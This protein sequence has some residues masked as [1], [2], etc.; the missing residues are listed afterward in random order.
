MIHKTSKPVSM[1]KHGLNYYLCTMG[2]YGPAVALGIIVTLSMGAVYIIYRIRRGQR[3]SNVP[4]VAQAEKAASEERCGDKSTEKP[5]ENREAQHSPESHIKEPRAALSVPGEDQCFDPY[6]ATADMLDQHVANECY[7]NP[8]SE[9]PV[10]QNKYLVSHEEDF[11]I[12]TEY[13]TGHL[14]DCHEQS[15][16]VSNNEQQV[17]NHENHVANHNKHP[18]QL[19]YEDEEDFSYHNQSPSDSQEY[20]SHHQEHVCNPSEVKDIDV[21]IEQRAENQCVNLKGQLQEKF[22]KADINIQQATVSNHQEHPILEMRNDD[23]ESR[24]VVQGLSSSMNHK[25]EEDGDDRNGTE[26]TM[27]NLQESSDHMYL[28]NNVDDLEGNLTGQLH[29]NCEKSEVNI[30]EATNDDEKSLNSS[31]TEIFEGLPEVSL[32]KSLWNTAE[33]EEQPKVPVDG[34]GHS[35]VDILKDTRATTVDGGTSSKKVAAVHPMPQ[36][37]M[38]CF[39]THFLT[40]S[41]SQLLAVTGNLQELGG[42]ENFF[43][44]SQANNGFWVGSVSLPVNSHV[45]WK[46]VLLEHGKIE[47]WEECNNHN[48]ETRCDGDIHLHKSWGYL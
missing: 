11:S 42:W 25:P 47:R 38:V 37:V 26:A 7:S 19:M 33:L 20:L 36:S 10:H 1:D 31:E 24:N 12:H 40:R 30:M 23:E 45:E 13:L 44:L 39:Q 35:K 5:L 9:H 34:L 14:G 4:Q 8:V 15:E 43:P 2:K 16:L 6:A 32:D 48:L 17:G 41:P 28:S 27:V 22:K 18:G 21:K 46:F 29:D 3:K